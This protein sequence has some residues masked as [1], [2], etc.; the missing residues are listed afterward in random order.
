MTEEKIKL[1]ET[2]IKNSFE[3]Q[4][5]FID[6]AIDEKRD[7]LYVWTITDI[8]NYCSL[9]IVPYLYSFQVF[10]TVRNER[11]EICIC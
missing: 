2:I 8:K 6:Y 10:A 1:A 4:Y 7:Y 3:Y 9:S 11:I 5:K